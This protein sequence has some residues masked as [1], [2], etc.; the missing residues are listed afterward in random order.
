[1]YL[2]CIFFLSRNIKK[3]NKINL[4]KIYFSTNVTLIDWIDLLRENWSSST[5]SR[6]PSLLLSE[7]LEILEK[8]A[9]LVPVYSNTTLSLLWHMSGQTGISSY[10][11]TSKHVARQAFTDLELK[12][13]PMRSDL[14]YSYAWFLKNLSSHPPSV[15]APVTGVSVGGYVDGPVVG[16]V[17]GGPASTRP[18]VQPLLSSSSVKLDRRKQ[19]FF[20]LS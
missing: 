13:L 19:F 20:L 1:M 14:S 11:L 8:E 2:L 12:G 16:R 15:V 10:N 4:S 7:T 9:L 6:R 18:A 3:I 5:S 17:G